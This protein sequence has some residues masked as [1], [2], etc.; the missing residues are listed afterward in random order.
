L[1][2]SFG[3]AHQHKN[4]LL[5]LPDG[6]LLKICDHIAPKEQAEI[7]AEDFA[8]PVFFSLSCK[9]LLGICGKIMQTKTMDVHA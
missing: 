5:G 2:G 3:S 1:Q 8:H 9:R 6:L 4:T 7:T